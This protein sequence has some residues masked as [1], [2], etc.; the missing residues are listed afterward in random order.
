V[1]EQSKIGLRKTQMGV[2]TGKKALTRGGNR[3]KSSRKP[4]VRSGRDSFVIP[5]VRLEKGHRKSRQRKSNARDS[6]KAYENDLLLSV[7]DALG[8]GDA[9]QEGKFR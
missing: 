9:S 7:N 4:Q 3:L 8:T 5:Q 6:K 1:S 2:S